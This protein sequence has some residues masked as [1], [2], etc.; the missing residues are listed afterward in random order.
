MQRDVV[1]TITIDPTEYE[2]VE[3]TDSGALNLVSEMLWGDCE[4]SNASS[5]PRK[6]VMTCGTER[7]E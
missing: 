4:S 6:V 5:V 3:D 2:G 7:R 1:I